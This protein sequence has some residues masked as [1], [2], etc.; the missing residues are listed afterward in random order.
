[1][2]IL[3][4]QVNEP[5]PSPSLR[6]G[7][8]LPPALEQLILRCLAKDPAARYRDGSALAIALEDL[9]QALPWRAID[10]SIV[11]IDVDG[12]RRDRHRIEHRRT[13]RPHRVIP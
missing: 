11:E 12:P 5:V 1:M 13:A 7:E 8:A 9:A 4:K 10:R 2:L 6:R 3:A